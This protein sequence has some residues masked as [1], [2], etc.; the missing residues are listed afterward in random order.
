MTRQTPGL[1]WTAPP[2]VCQF[3]WCSPTISHE[4]T[5]TALFP[6]RMPYRS[7]PKAT[8]RIDNPCRRE[9][10]WHRRGCVHRWLI[11]AQCPA[12]SHASVPGLLPAASW[13]PLPVPPPIPS[14]CAQTPSL[15]AVGSADPPSRVLQVPAHCQQHSVRD[16]WTVQR[17][18]RRTDWCFA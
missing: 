13:S 5:R 1:A 8:G 15:R 2:F 6:R 16:G 14:G 4:S 10:L 18:A 7:S 11:R 9:R 12:V 17:T 3:H